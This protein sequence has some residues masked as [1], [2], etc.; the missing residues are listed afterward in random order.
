MYEYL[1]QLLVE[2]IE[3]PDSSAGIIT[4]L[5]DIYYEKCF[6]YPTIQIIKFAKSL[7]VNV[8]KNVKKIMI[9]LREKEEISAGTVAK[10]KDIIIKCLTALPLAPIYKEYFSFFRE[11]FYYNTDMDT[12]DYNLACDNL[13]IFNS[14]LKSTT[15]EKRRSS[16]PSKS[17]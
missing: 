12:V 14:L 6:K 13:D 15:Y 3:M 11:V 9:Y 17:S 10:M 16:S 2:C 5:I 7:T 1:Y 4:Q 8:V